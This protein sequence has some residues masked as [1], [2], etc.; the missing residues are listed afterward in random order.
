[1]QDEVVHGPATDE[2]SG[3]YLSRGLPGDAEKHVV[4]QP[5]PEFSEIFH[6]SDIINQYLFKK[7]NSANVAVTHDDDWITLLD[8]GKLKPEDFVQ[9]NSSRVEEIVANNFH[10][11]SQEGV[12]FLQ[13]KNDVATD[14]NADQPP[15]S[16]P[17][18]TKGREDVLDDSF[19]TPV[20]VEA[21]PPAYGTE[22]PERRE[23]T[24]VTEK[25][26]LLPELHGVPAL[27]QPPDI[28]WL[29][30]PYDPR[31]SKHLLRFDVIFPVDQICYQ[32]S[33]NARERL[34][35]EDLD[36]PAFREPITKMRIT[37]EQRPFNWTIDVD[38]PHRIRCRDVFEAI[39]SSFN[40]QLTLGELWRLPDRCACEDAFRIRTLV[41]KSSQMERSLGWKRVDALLH[42]TVFHGLTMNPD[43]EGEWVLNLGAPLPVASRGLPLSPT[44]FFSRRDSCSTEEDSA[45]SSDDHF[46]SSTSP[47]LPLRSRSLYTTEAVSAGRLGSPS[48]TTLAVPPRQQF[49]RSRPAHR[50]LGPR[51]HQR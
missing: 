11:V 25:P 19:N 46:N 27:P 14:Y 6:P 16:P 7:E 4:V 3:Y 22:S 38:N 13:G 39:Y 15:A 31:T 50:P 20:D 51:S 28:H 2:A 10:V 37:F 48:V 34:A 41:L 30:L 8:E 12:V 43:S 36:E 26:Y 33:N 49:V 5:M 45:E 18:G 35:D 17:I 9:M 44:S 32:Y 23:S 42:H 21:P 24:D 47:I 40:Q 1:M 29:L